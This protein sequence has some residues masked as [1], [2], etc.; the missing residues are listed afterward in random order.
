VSQ[1][2]AR[3]GKNGDTIDLLAAK[4]FDEAVI[5]PHSFRSAF[6]AARSRIPRRFGYRGQ[7]RSWLL[8]PGVRRGSTDRHQVEDYRELLEAM[9]VALPEAWLPRLELPRELRDQGAERLARA[10]LARDRRPPRVALFPGA[11]FGPSKRWPAHR[12]SQLARDLRRRLPEVQIGIVVGP[13]EVWTGVQ[14]RETS[15]RIHP[16]LGADLDLAQLASV[17]CHFDLLIT[18]DSGPMHLAAALGVPC[19][20]LFGP[21]DPRRTAPVGARHRVLHL[22]RWCSPCFRRRCPLLHHRCLKGITAE[23]VLDQALEVLEE[24]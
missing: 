4:G 22:D 5:L 9:H 24:V 23:A 6:L 18:N 15:G 2:L 20:A 1:G 16:I 11:E 12:F 13:G 21:T 3:R 17:L 8:A 19:V 10:G 14:I 7:L